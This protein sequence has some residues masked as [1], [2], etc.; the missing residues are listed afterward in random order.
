M[1]ASGQPWDPDFL[2]SSALLSDYSELAE[3]LTSGGD[4]PTLEAYT[5]FAEQERRDRAPEL[6]AVRFAPPRPRRRRARAR[7][8]VEVEVE[9][10][11]LYDGRIALDREVPC[12]G[13]SYHDLCNVLVWAAFPRAKRALHERQ[14]RALRGVLTGAPSRLPNRRTR[15]QDALTLFDEGGSLLVLPQ[16]GRERIVLFGHA[17]ME[18]VSFQ[19]TR[20]NSAALVIELPQAAPQ[21]RALFELLDRELAVRLRDPNQL[22]EPNFERSLAIVSELAERG[23][24]VSERKPPSA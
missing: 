14:Y 3:S 10:R 9:V 13:A 15:E 20:I 18:H 7:A 5:R 4:W 6:E 19:T 1:P 8:K 21:G 11:E 23:L 24:V 12:L 22:R 17:L 2:R 16:G